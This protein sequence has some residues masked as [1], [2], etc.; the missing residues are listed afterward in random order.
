M[1]GDGRR[2]NTI[3]SRFTGRELSPGPLIENSALAGQCR[4]HRA[5]GTAHNPGTRTT[6]YPRHRSPV[7]ERVIHGPHSM[8]AQSPRFVVGQHVSSN[9]G[10]LE[11][12]TGT[13]RLAKGRTPVD[14]RRTVSHSPRAISGAEPRPIP[15]IRARHAPA[16][17]FADGRFTRTIRPVVGGAHSAELTSRGMMTCRKWLRDCCCARQRW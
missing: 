5:G 14:V 2:R 11:P 16:D 12:T 10:A 3:G 7:D 6:P 17:R 15:T 1:A 9:P 8:S 4:R 13:G